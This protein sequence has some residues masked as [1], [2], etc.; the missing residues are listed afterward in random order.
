MLMYTSGTTGSP[1]GVQHTVNSMVNAARSMTERGHLTND[2]VLLVGSPVGHMLGLAAGV[3]LA[4]FNRATMV[5]QE[6]W[7]GRHA[8]ELIDE[9]KVTFSGGATPFLADLVREVQ[10]GA[11]R[12]ETLRLFLCAGAPIPPVLVRQA[13]EVLGTTV[14]SVWGMTESLASTMTE[15]ER[16]GQLSAT[17]DGRP[18][19]GMQVKV[20]DDSGRTRAAGERGRLLVRG[21]Q[22]HIGYM[23]IPPEDTFDAEGWMDTGDLAY[24]LADEDCAGYIRIAGRTKDV[25]I[26]GGENIPVVEI[27]NLLVEHPAITIAALVGYP[28][29]RLGERAC[30]FVVAEN[31][32][33]V[34]LDDLRLWMDEKKVAKQYWPER[35]E[36]IQAM[37]RTP[38]GKIQKFLL[39]DMLQS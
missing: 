18:V 38:S 35:I 8:L 2:D 3:L 10:A 4:I 7:N 1:K 37:P 39:R 23:G 11:P 21:A 12:P 5:L 36:I 22:L 25:I 14:T 6:S 29:E 16:A 17:S 15:P 31:G 28:D 26:R 30:A 24:G 13:S 9:Y 27:E 34:S 19:A 33:S 20:V 32:A